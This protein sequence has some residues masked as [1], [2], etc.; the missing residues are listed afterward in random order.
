M[1]CPLCVVI[2]VI[3]DCHHPHLWTVVLATGLIIETSHLAHIC[4]YTPS[5]YK[6]ISKWMQPLF[7]KWQ[8]FQW[9]SFCGSPDYLVKL[10]AFIFGS[11][12]YLYWGH[13]HTK[14][15]IYLWRISLKLLIFKNVHIVHSPLPF[16]MCF[17]IHLTINPFCIACIYAFLK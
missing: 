10:G 8:P 16:T 4:T 15:I 3:L 1:N 2:V 11:V 6:W 5:I 9:S 13:R 14:K 12:V 7:L 17:E